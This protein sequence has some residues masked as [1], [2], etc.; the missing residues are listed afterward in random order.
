MVAVTKVEWWETERETLHHLRHGDHTAHVPLADV[1]I[2]D[3]RVT[4]HLPVS[5]H[6]TQREGGREGGHS[7]RSRYTALV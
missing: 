3:I 1:L 6:M 5:R 2:E 4:E 7:V